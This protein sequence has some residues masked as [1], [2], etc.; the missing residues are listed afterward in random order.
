[1]DKNDDG[2]YLVSGRFTNTIYKVSG[3]DGSIIWRLGGKHSSFAMLDFDFSAQHDA[4][5]RNSKVARAPG[6]EYISLMNNAAGGALTTSNYSS[7]LIVELDMSG[8]TATLVKEFR[9]PDNCLTRL[10]GNLQVLPNSNVL[11][12][13]SE[14]AY[15][16]EFSAKGAL[17]AV[18][19]FTSK[20]FVTYRAYKFNFT[21]SPAE[22]PRIKAFVYGQSAATGTSVFH[23]SWNG[24][25]EVAS[26]RFSELR[27]DGSSS[28]VCTARKRGFETTCMV[29]GCHEKVYA[30][31]ISAKGTVLGKS[32]VQAAVMPD[33]W[34]MDYG[35]DGCENV[36]AGSPF[37]S[38]VLAGDGKPDQDISG[39]RV[40]ARYPLNGIFGDHD[41]AASSVAFG[42]TIACALSIISLLCLVT[43]LRLWRGVG[44][45]FQLWPA[46][47]RQR[48]SFIF[49]K[50]DGGGSHQDA[51]SY[52]CDQ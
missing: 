23:A 6:I 7:G 24:A 31:A 19:N 35:P 36:G 40:V 4:R 45:R 32:D 42:A 43:R 2:D 30:E 15:T 22:F 21:S 25:T 28:V 49:E 27:R 10:R 46:P 41:W 1:M 47:C 8:M 9:R 33:D 17:V 37:M 52:D 11:T 29:F 18:T 26:W 13:W 38:H 3:V 39:L 51:A 16:T 5:F 44:S 14:N 50:E 34:L 20:R 48:R 12:S